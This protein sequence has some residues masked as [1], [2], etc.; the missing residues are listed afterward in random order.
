MDKA[1]LLITETKDNEISMEKPIKFKNRRGHNL[2]GML[3]VPDAPSRRKVGIIIS[4]NAVKYRIGTFRFHTL[5]A[6]DLCRYG[7]YVMYFDPEGIGDSEGSFEEKRLEEHHLDIQRGKYK[8]DLIDAVSFFKAQVNLDNLVLLG[9]CGGAISVLIAAAAD[10]D[11]DGAIFLGLPILLDQVEGESYSDPYGEAIV[12]DAQARIFIAD[13]IHKILQPHTW[14]RFFARKINIRNEFKALLMAFGVAIKSLVEKA[15][16]RMRSTHYAVSTE[17]PISAH[18]RYNVF[19][20]TSFFSSL[21][22]EQRLLLVFGE[23]DPVTWV[24]RKEFEDKALV[25]GNPFDGLYEIHRIKDA[26]HIFSAK[27]SQVQVKAIIKRWLESNFS[28]GPD[29]SNDKE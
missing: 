14:K 3:F 26:N 21:S 13:Q 12:A 23:R 28:A 18:P 1:T 8:E 6:R 25:P 19:V 20:Q 10:D 4:V 29:D 5:L 11:V 16:T 17:I 15:L 7:Y 27:E 22:K 24:F 9:L 2:F